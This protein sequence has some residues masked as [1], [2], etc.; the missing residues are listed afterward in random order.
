M[1]SPLIPQVEIFFV[2]KKVKADP[3]YNPLL[4]YP[5]NLIDD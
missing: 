3:Y 4:S 1:K 2:C 5:P